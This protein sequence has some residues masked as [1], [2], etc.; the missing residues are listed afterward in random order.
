LDHTGALNEAFPECKTKAGGP[1][2]KSKQKIKIFFWS[3]FAILIIGALGNMIWRTADFEG[4]LS[5]NSKFNDS[6]TQIGGS[7]V[8]GLLFVLAIAIV[9]GL[10]GSVLSYLFRRGTK[11]PKRAWVVFMEIS[12]NTKNSLP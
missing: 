12:S 5:Y 10:L 2:K 7:F 6:I 8:V 3:M 9:G 4:D 1:I 11:E